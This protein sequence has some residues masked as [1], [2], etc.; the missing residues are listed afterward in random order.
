L[1][2]LRLGRDL[3]LEHRIP[4]HLHED[5]DQLLIPALAKGLEIQIRELGQPEEQVRADR[6]AVVLDEIEV[7]RGDPEPLR[8]GGLGESLAEAQGAYSLTQVRDRFHSDSLHEL[9]FYSND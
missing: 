9:T 5:R 3:P 1:A 4:E 8:Q 2:R 6:P 7:A